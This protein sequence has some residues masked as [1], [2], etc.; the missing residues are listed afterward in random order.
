MTRFEQAKRGFNNWEREQ[1]KTD[2]MYPKY[3]H[4]CIAWI[5]YE[6][7]TDM[8]NNNATSEEI[9]NFSRALIEFADEVIED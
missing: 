4:E 6:Q 9:A 1:D 5:L 8:I 3:A 2:V 7:I